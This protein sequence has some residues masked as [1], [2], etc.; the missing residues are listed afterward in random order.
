MTFAEVSE[1]GPA[2]GGVFGG[3]RW[4]GFAPRAAPVLAGRWDTSS[5]GRRTKRLFWVQPELPEVAEPS[6][7]EWLAEILGEA[8]D[9]CPHCGAKGSLVERTTFEELSWLVGIILS[10]FGQP[11][12]AGVCR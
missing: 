7:E 12:T 5:T 1:D 8:V 6:L 4:S 3:K 11:T 2:A 9:Q 10:L